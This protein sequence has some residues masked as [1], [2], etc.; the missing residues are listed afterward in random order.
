MSNKFFIPTDMGY[1][2]QSI[3]G[4]IINFGIIEFST[5]RWIEVLGGEQEAMEA[6]KRKLADRIKSAVALI[7]DSALSSAAKKQ[8]GDLWDEA[9]KLTAIRNR[10]AHNPLCITIDP[11]NQLAV[12]SVIDLKTMTPNGQNP[13]ERLDR[14][15]IAD[16]GLRVGEIGRRLNDLLTSIPNKK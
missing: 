12:L 3:G 14:T 5:L 13:I 15:K 6:R 7:P 2:S 16:I 4:L 10:I 11:K 9:L 1:W 8:A